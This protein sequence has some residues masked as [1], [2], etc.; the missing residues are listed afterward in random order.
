MQSY[1]IDR[2]VTEDEIFQDYNQVEKVLQDIVSAVEADTRLLAL[3]TE[4]K[5]L[6]ISQ[7][8]TILQDVFKT[9]VRS[10]VLTADEPGVGEWQKYPYVKEE[11]PVS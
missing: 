6:W 9:V 11:L 5:D 8:T 10:V 4:K 1:C 2:T 7:R 3:R